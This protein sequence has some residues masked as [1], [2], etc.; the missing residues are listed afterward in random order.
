[1]SARY[2]IDYDAFHHQAQ[3]GACFI[4]QIVKGN[5]NYPA[6]IVYK[7]E[8]TLAFLD[9]YPIQY[10]HTLVTLREHRE[11]VTGDFSE[12]DYVAL[13]RSVYR[14]AEAVREEVQA[15]RIYIFTLGSNQGNAHVHWHIVPLPP[16]IPYH[17]QQFA[18]LRRSE[19]GILKMSEEE[20]AALAERLR[21]RVVQGHN[22]PKG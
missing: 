9:K 18:A 19:I 17:E 7:D 22:S 12:E 21:R 4:Y 15:E 3:S 20:K 13:Q 1:M 5:P 10:R 16:G 14:V 8:I 2:Q 6:T 11:Q